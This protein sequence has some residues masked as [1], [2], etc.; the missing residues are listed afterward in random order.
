VKWSARDGRLNLSAAAYRIKQSGFEALDGSYDDDTGEFVAS[1]GDRYPNYGTIDAN[2][3]CCFKSDPEHTLRSKGI[4]F[5]LSGEILPGWQVSGSYTFNETKQEGAWFDLFDNRNKPIVSLQP[6][7][8]YKVWMSY[9]FGA[10]GATGVLR[11]LALSGGING[12]S[13]GYQEGSGCLTEFLVTNDVTGE[14]SCATGGSY[15][16]NFTVPAYAVLSGRIDYRFTGNWSIAI[17]LENILDKTYYQTVG[18]IDSGNWY[19]APRNV[20][21]TL[22]GK[23]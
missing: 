18:G 3:S 20:T 9:D 15:D 14:A 21:A 12:Q 13:S 22:R 2:H 5:E 6:K 4:D 17:N 19:G 7:Q 10:T 23:W 1:N 16:Y 11:N 8:L